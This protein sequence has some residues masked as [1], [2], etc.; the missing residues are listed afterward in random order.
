M[1]AND[2]SLFVDAIFDSK[3]PAPQNMRDPNNV[4][5]PKRFNVYRNNVIVGLTEAVKDGFPL[6]ERIVGEEFFEAMA[7]EYVR[8]NPPASPLL[9]LYGEN[10]ADFIAEFEPAKSVPYLADMARLEYYKRRAYFAGDADYRDPTKTDLEE[11][12]ALPLSLHPSVFVMRSAYPIVSIYERLNAGE[13]EVK[14]GSEE[15]LIWRRLGKVEV[16]LAPDGFAHFVD[17][18]REN[19]L[20]V[21]VAKFQEAHPEFAIEPLIPLIIQLSVEAE[22]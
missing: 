7:R 1:Q 22:K 2:Q 21:A 12:L 5:A 10:F 17:L 13:G 8:H 20:D 9:F 18:A 15:A 14:A 3:L 6:V 19:A 4:Y 11:L 16:H